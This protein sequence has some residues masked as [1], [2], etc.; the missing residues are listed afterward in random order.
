MIPK[1]DTLPAI[2]RTGVAGQCLL[3]LMPLL[4]FTLCVLGSSAALGN[5]A[6]TSPSHVDPGATLEWPNP[7]VVPGGLVG[8][9]PGS[10][11]VEPDGQYHYS[12]PLEVPPG[13]AGMQPALSLV[14]GS[15]GGNG[16][17]GVGWQ[18]GGVSTIHQ[19]PKTH[20]VDGVAQPVDPGRLAAMCLDGARLIK[21][22]GDGVDAPSDG[23][24]YR[25]ENDN[26]ARIV[27]HGDLENL[28]FVPY[29]E[30][31][32]KDGLILRYQTPPGPSSG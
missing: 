21:L 6:H 12:L 31:W 30:V 7:A 25:T 8:T 27:F 3:T 13:R 22:S 1:R 18:L 24:V 32:A 29:F 16:I 17:A 19:C 14:Y 4:L 26:F 5:D 28:S 23:S 2:G 15:G 11:G 20:A 10:G 9:L